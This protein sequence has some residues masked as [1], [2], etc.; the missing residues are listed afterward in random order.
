MDANKYAADWEVPARAPVIPLSQKGYNDDEML[1]DPPSGWKYGFPKPYRPLDGES[2]EQTLLRDGYPQKEIDNGG[3]RH[4]RFIGGGAR[5]IADVLGAVVAPPPEPPRLGDWMQVASGGQF[6]PL[7][8][9]ADEIN[10]EDIA[11]SLA[12]QCRYAGHCLRFYSVAEHSVLMARHLAA[13][14]SPDALWALLHDAS[15]AYL[16]DVPRPVKPF[17]TGYKEAEA[18]V[19]A[20]VC[21]RFGLP[22]LMPTEVHEA[23][24]RILVDEMSQN[25]T[26]PPVP[27]NIPEVGLGVTL[28]LWTPEQAKA[29]FL[30]TYWSIIETGRH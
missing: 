2:L 4:C 28:Q 19:M 5:N 21:D 14:G 10:I 25:M 18:R 16:V 22:I 8:P 3:A 27:W 30:A 13:A 20:S 15:E 7:D 17:L 24:N 9:R 23:D 29:E 12:M 11:H 26:P 6:W 1:Y